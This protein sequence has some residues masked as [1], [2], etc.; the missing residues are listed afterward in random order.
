M[1]FSQKAYMSEDMKV[2][3]KEINSFIVSECFM[4]KWT[5]QVRQVLQAG[6]IL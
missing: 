4:A 2:E 6:N 5:A 1:T 3:Q